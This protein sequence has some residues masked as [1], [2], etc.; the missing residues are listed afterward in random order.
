MKEEFLHYV[1]QF[2]KFDNHNLKTT[3]GHSLQ[4]VSPGSHNHNSGPDFF[5][6]QLVIDGQLWA[7]NV[8]L[9]IESSLWFLHQHHKDP[10]YDSVIL[11]VVWEHT[12]EVSRKDT[13][14]IPTLELK[15]RIP[16]PMLG[17]YKKLFSND[18]KW[19]PCEQSLT[20]IDSFMYVHWLERLYVERLER[21]SQ[22]LMERASQL[23]NH[24]E[25]L[26]FEMLCKNF[27][28]K[29]NGTAFLSIAQ[30]IPFS[31]IQKCS[32]QLLSLEAILL[33]QAGLLDATAEAPY[34]K[35][36][37]SSYKY[38][39]RKFKLSNDGVIAPK[40]FRLRPSN[41][42]TVRLAQLAALYV[43]NGQLFSKVIA[44]REVQ[45]LYELFTIETSEFWRTHY[46]F[47]SSS[48]LRSTQLTKK[49]INLLFI[50]T[51]LPMRFAYL[52]FL[53]S[54]PSE[55]ILQLAGE[56]PPEANTIILRFQ[57]LGLV[58][59]NA[60]ETQALLQL[61]ELY[62]DARRCLNCEIGNAILKVSNSIQ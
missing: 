8:E 35:E 61:K 15:H 26:L 56:L 32:D 36:L 18:T 48:Q 11:H 50:N 14:L 31:L 47:T 38:S 19:I 58:A 30:S 52:R 25:A 27:G 54:H 29:V 37:I 55:E 16:K 17:T 23:N 1:W 5:N 43:N 33:G 34:V 20:E 28:L 12:S 21:K 59:T 9:H 42:P 4:I 6:A 39:K 53:G 41:F 7:G 51:V 57:K 62:C 44:I 46:T 40:F 49:F 60:L 22:F 13:T 3:Q 24:W 10:A 2:Q 45:H